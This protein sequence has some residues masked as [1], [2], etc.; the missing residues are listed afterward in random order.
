M[1]YS[2]IKKKLASVSS[3]LSYACQ[4]APC[5]RLD[6]YGKRWPNCDDC[7]IKAAKKFIIGK[8]EEIETDDTLD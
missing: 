3:H 2:T 6:G 8:E 1:I 7:H 5:D 4:D